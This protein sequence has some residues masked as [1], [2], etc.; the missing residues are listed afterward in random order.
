[1]PLGSDRHDTDQSHGDGRT[2][3]HAA[4]FRAVCA[5]F[6]ALRGCRRT[7]PAPRVQHHGR[8]REEHDGGV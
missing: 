5:P 6:G 7:A 3:L 4:L 8:K 2:P 1:V